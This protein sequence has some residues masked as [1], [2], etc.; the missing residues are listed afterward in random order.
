MPGGKPGR[1]DLKVVPYKPHLSCLLSPWARRRFAVIPI[2][3]YDRCRRVVKITRLWTTDIPVCRITPRAPLV[4]QAGMP[5]FHCRTQHNRPNRGMVRRQLGGA[6][7][8]HHL[9]LSPRR[10]GGTARSLS[11]VFTVFLA[12]F[13]SFV[14]HIIQM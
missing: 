13:A 6:G 8:P 14:V 10:R 9:A 4:R 2:G 3:K 5:I 1:H 7:K 11:N 12:F